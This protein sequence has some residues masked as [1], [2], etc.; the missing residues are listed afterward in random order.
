MTLNSMAG[1]DIIDLFLRGGIIMWPLLLCSVLGL[2]IIVDRFI[3]YLMIRA[4]Y[5]RFGRE[6]SQVILEDGKGTAAG[7]AFCKRKRH[8]VARVAEV[9]LENLEQNDS[10]RVDLIKKQGSIEIEKVERWLRMLSSIAHIA[11]LMGLLGTVLGMVAAFAQIDMNEGIVEAGD[12][13]SGI[14]KA[15]LT[16][17]FGL[18][19]AIPCMASFHAFE[20]FADKVSRQMQFVVTSLDECFGKVTDASMAASEPEAQD[21]EMNVIR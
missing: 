8:P 11:P 16:T 2:A 19:I 17:V 3:A 14:W 9:Y 4:D 12:L 20:G 18:T 15:L 21:A 10:L 13:A 7:I 6:L 5:A 1:T